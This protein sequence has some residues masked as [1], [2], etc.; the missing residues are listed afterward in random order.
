MHLIHPDSDC[1]QFAE[2]PLDLRRD[3]QRWMQAFAQMDTTKSITAA[4]KRVASA[5]GVSV[6][7]ATRYYY[8][9]KSNDGHWSALADG[10]RAKRLAENV[11]GTQSREFRNW[12]TKLAED[13][14]RN[15]KAAYRKFKT[16][17]AAR[18]N[19][20]GFE[21]YSGW[22]NI[23]F[24]YRTF[25]RI[26]QQ[27]TDK[28]RLRSIRVS[29]SSKSGSAL[30]QVLT[31]RVGLYPGAVYQ[32]D[33]VWHDNFVTLGR[34]PVPKRVLEL[35]VLDLFSGCR[36]HWGAKPR[37]KNAD[38]V[39]ENLKEREMRFFLAG[40][41]WNFGTSPR[42]TRMMVEHGTAALRD[43]VIAILHDSGLNISVDRQ[44]IEGK[45]AALTGYW[46]GT[47]GGNF[48]AKAALESLHNLI[49]NDL[50]NLALQTG[51]HHSGIAAPVNT[52]RQL[53]YIKNI[54]SEVL[55]KVPHRADLLRLP[56]LDFHSQFLPFLRDYYEFGLNGRT[57]HELEGWE[58]LGFLT[59]EYTAVPG[60]G[61]FL[62]SQQFLDLPREPQAIIAAAS[63]NDPANW[64]R[65]RKLSPLEVWN[66]GRSDL[67]RAPAPLICDILG[68]D[69]GREVT[70]KGSYI[71]FR[72]QDISPDEMIY[73]ARAIH[74][75]GAQRELRD[76][77]KFF[78]FANP[79]APDTLFLLDAQDRYLGH[80]MLEQ[81]ITATDR[82]A[83]IVAAGHKAH[84]NAEILQPL[85]N[86]HA[87][88]VRDAQ[89]MREHNRR[90]ADGE[91]VT[92]E[93]ISDDRS[94]AAHRAVTTRRTNEWESADTETIFENDTPKPATISD[95]EIADWLND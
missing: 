11:K 88:T 39:M 63:K 91:A 68:K 94:A 41:L 42:G 60:S 65:R 83:L 4:L 19:I 17:W 45:Q 71:R 8:N 50:S 80:C 84:R 66:S 30:A 16:A 55:K 10:R 54:V 23:P 86:R 40:V 52:D 26:I 81:R 44:P 47:E 15:S 57:E 70:V 48:R 13:H 22:P 69:L 62:N 89:E 5:M 32:F 58:A 37:I 78:A 76:G 56:S 14:H 73:Q 6:A 25:A 43:D 1:E 85:R 21:D 51:S 95:S 82:S 92:P 18:E 29:T 77:E 12:I 3:V 67:R 9:L 64:S 27:E 53:T 2:C 59:T 20:P 34:D 74:L 90:V 35:G 24:S 79:F 38:G 61:Q 33:D 31:T 93:E 28:R 46:P 7:T 75:N 87:E 49:H 72:D 36:F